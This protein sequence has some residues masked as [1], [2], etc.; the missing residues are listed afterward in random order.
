MLSGHAS[1][2]RSV[3]LLRATSGVTF[4]VE[5]RPVGVATEKA[6]L[7]MKD[8]TM[9]CRG[10]CNL[11]RCLDV[12]IAAGLVTEATKASGTFLSSGQN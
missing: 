8:N 6:G 2:V 3:A 11:D 1:T 12:G 5:V 9:L 7:A 10:S 4:F